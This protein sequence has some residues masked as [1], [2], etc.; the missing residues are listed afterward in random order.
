M[1][2]GDEK[3]SNAMESG[4]D[5]QDLS[6]TKDTHLLETKIEEARTLEDTRVVEA[7]L[8]N[9]TLPADLK[10]RAE[11]L[12]ADCFVKQVATNSAIKQEEDATDKLGSAEIDKIITP[13]TIQKLSKLAFSEKIRL[14]LLGTR[15]E[16]FILIRD[17]N[18]VIATTALK[19]PKLGKNELEAIAQMRNINQEILEAIAKHRPWLKNYTVVLN[20]VRNPKTPP[21]VSVRLLSLIQKHDLAVLAKDR[22]I[23][24][25]LRRNAARAFSTRSG[26]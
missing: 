16:R 10:Q 13:S 25:I 1:V 4:K 20:L 17:P 6:S 24:E 7:I 26:G 3:M 9:P 14:A 22:N 19:S 5:L 11:E 2:T 15:E 21:P 8:L 12:L 18:K 23:P